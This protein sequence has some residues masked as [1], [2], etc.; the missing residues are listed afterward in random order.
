MSYR[1]TDLLQDVWNRLGQ[2]RTWK[3]TGGSTTTVVNSAWTGI[4]EAIYEDNDPAL[5]YGTVV[6]VRDAGGAGASPE[7]EFGAISLYDASSNT[8]T[9][10]ALTAAIASG[11]KVGIASPQFP[12]EDMIRL[13]NIALQKLGEI[14]LPD[15][16]LTVVANQTEYALPSTIRQKPLR[17]RKQHLQTTNNNL[18][19]VVNNWDVIPAT[20]GSNWT[21]VIP[22]LTQGYKLEILYR[23]VH[24]EINA[25][26][27]TIL[28]TIHPELATCALITEAYQWYN[29]MLG[30]TNQYFLQREN[31]AL[32]D[33]EAA[34][35]TYPMRH[36]MEQVTGFPHWKPDTR[37]VPLTSDSKG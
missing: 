4:D 31:K 25:W 33:L 12:L 16:S 30:G 29:N 5:V 37:Y 17:V 20:T 22:Y 28:D 23:S 10:D 7:G 27:D 35:V 24:P 19:E 9:M 26:N 32:Q 2:M 3:V 14:E 15:T 13:A 21:L 6:A 36:A 8:I 18:W 11:D 34:K 1:L